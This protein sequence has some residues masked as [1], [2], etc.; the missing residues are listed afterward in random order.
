MLP[1]GGPQVLKVCPG[2][3]FVTRFRKFKGACHEEIACFGQFP[4]GGWGGGGFLIRG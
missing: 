4:S 2:I 3:G 1:E